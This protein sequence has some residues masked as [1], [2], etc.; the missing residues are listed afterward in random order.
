MKMVVKYFLSW[1]L[2]FED[3]VKRENTDKSVLHNTAPTTE[4]YLVL[5]QATEFFL[6][7]LVGAKT[8]YGCF[9]E[10]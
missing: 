9:N 2:G 10:P 5:F 3:E 8:G 4:R 7:L 1:H 6:L